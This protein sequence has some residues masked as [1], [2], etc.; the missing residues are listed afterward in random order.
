MPDRGV[1]SL[2]RVIV[3]WSHRQLFRLDVVPFVKSPER[4]MFV[5]KHVHVRGSDRNEI[6]NLA[7]IRTRY[8]HDRT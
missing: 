5:L 4:C 1:T 8:L 7:E 2:G 3:F 6:S